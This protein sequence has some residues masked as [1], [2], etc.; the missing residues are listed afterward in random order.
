MEWRPFQ[1]LVDIRQRLGPFVIPDER[2]P[3]EDSGGDDA[4]RFAELRKELDGK[5]DKFIRDTEH[6]DDLMLEMALLQQQFMLG[7]RMASLKQGPSSP[8]L[9]VGGTADAGAPSSKKLKM[10]E[11]TDEIQ[12][13]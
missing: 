2:I 12:T 9:A 13:Q 1:S 3:K 7:K 4:K 5:R 6:V 11:E 8:G 10:A